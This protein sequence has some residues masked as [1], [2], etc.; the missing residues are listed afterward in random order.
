MPEPAAPRGEVAAMVAVQSAL[1]DRPGVLIT[2]RALSHFGEHSIGWIIVSLLGAVLSPRQQ[3][4][5]LMA[6]IGA[7]AAH[8]AA[9]L[10]KRVVRRKRPQHPGV[11]L[12][13][14]GVRNAPR[15]AERPQIRPG[16]SVS[17]GIPQRE[18]ATRPP[19]A[20]DLAVYSVSEQYAEARGRLG[21]GR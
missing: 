18:P 10:V 14:L 16:A 4:D 17:R 9:V 5:W 13:G 15:S 1:A 6:G 3:R 19:E 12:R 21:A 7:F 8:A 2:A 11:D 20:R